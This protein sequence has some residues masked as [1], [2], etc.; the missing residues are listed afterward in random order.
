MKIMS[1]EEYLQDKEYL[2]RGVVIVDVKAAY[3]ACNEQWRDKHKALLEELRGM[4]PR[5]DDEW[6]DES[7]LR[8][9]PVPGALSLNHERGGHI[10]IKRTIRMNKRL[11]R[12]V[13][14]GP[15]AIFEI[16]T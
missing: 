13:A 1:A 9:V 11:R 16:E 8:G 10:A 5:K 2:A 7:E 14:V 3:N 12:H 6:W 15:R 4:F